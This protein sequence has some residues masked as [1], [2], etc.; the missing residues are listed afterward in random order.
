MKHAYIITL[1]FAGLIAVVLFCCTNKKENYYKYQGQIQGTYFKVIYESNTDYAPQIDSLLKR[2]NQSLNNYDSSSLISQINRNEQVKTDSLFSTMFAAAKE[3]WKASGGYFDI[4]IAPVAN[5]WGFGYKPGHMP[6]STEIDSLMQFVGMENIF[7]I[8]GVVGKLDERVEIIGNA[9]AKGMSVDY[10]SQY[11]ESK[12]INNFLVD[13]GGEIRARG[14]SQKG[15]TWVVGIDKPFVDSMAKKR[16]IEGKIALDGMAVATSG[17]YRKY[18]IQ[19]G[20]RYGHSINPKTGYPAGSEILSATVIYPQCMYADA[21]ATAFMA[22]KTPDEALDMV[23]KNDELEAMFITQNEEG[24]YI[25]HTSA[26]FDE[27]INNN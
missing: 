26:G 6:D 12:G 22:M 16:E 8:K 4:T 7:L 1:V 23:N 11:L 17:D 5:A 2:F 25:T 20:V 21:W 27:L 10:L 19:N 24:A 9:I 18:K 3:V 15:K 13:I 14:K